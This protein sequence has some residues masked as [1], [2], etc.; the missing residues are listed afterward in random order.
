[1][2][3]VN[4][5]FSIPIIQSL[6]LICMALLY[7]YNT[8][9]NTLEDVDESRGN[10]WKPCSKEMEELCQLKQRNRETVFNSRRLQRTTP[11]IQISSPT[12]TVLSWRESDCIL[13]RSWQ[14]LRFPIKVKTAKFFWFSAVTILNDKGV[15]TSRFRHKKLCS[16]LE[17]E[18]Q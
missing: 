17:F 5:L 18:S 2:Q 1:M 8:V 9:K 16:S 3:W 7:P 10:N 14:E 13:T 15:V 11:T 12:G 4:L 6:L